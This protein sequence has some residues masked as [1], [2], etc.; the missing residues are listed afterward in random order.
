MHTTLLCKHASCPKLRQSTAL[1]KIQSYNFIQQAPLTS[2][3]SWMALNC[4]ST[5]LADPISQE[6]S[7]VTH[8]AHAQ[9]YKYIE[10]PWPVAQ[11]DGALHQNSHT[12]GIHPYTRS[13]ST[14]LAPKWNLWPH[15]WGASCTAAGRQ[16]C[17]QQKIAECSSRGENKRSGNKHNQKHANVHIVHMWFCLLSI[18][19]TVGLGREQWHLSARQQQPSCPTSRQTDPH[20]VFRIQ[21]SAKS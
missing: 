11:G 12:T 9:S 16:S 18:S 21:I 4:Q 14:W 2:N 13:E 3:S 17:A 1:I 10:K 19:H 6:M 20:L 8:I 7:L 15:T 5:R